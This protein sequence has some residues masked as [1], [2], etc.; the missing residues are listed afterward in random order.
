LLLR[1]FR[2]HTWKAVKAAGLRVLQWVALP[3]SWAFTKAAE[4]LHH[5]HQSSH[6]TSEMDQPADV[7]QV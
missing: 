4:A 5:F 2:P 6:N 3:A 7:A 1:R